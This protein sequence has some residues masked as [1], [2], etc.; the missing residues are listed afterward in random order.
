MTS[1]FFYWKSAS[2]TER[3]MKSIERPLLVLFLPVISFYHGKS[4]FLSV[5]VVGLELWCCQVFF[6][7]RTIV[8]G[9]RVIKSF[10]IIDILM[11]DNE[12]F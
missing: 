12:V 3:L 10:N 6:L 4:L 9:T 5:L 2:S 11:L 8:R 1:F 7:L